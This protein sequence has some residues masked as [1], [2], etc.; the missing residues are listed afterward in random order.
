MGHSQEDT[1]SFT[2][3]QW[4]AIA[5][6]ERLLKRFAALDLSIYVDGTL[7]VRR[8]SIEIEN[9]Y[10]KQADVEWVTIDTPGLDLD[11]GGW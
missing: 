10:V 6:M 4:A 8:G 11:G 1:M 5:A 3:K 7:S 9:G 2:K